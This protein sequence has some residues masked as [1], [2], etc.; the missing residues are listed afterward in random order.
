[1]AEQNDGKAIWL[2][3][4]QRQ[5]FNEFVEHFEETQGFEPNPGQAV[6]SA[7]KTALEVEA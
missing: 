2:N 4:E 7:C 6:Q 1:M 3:G 5:T